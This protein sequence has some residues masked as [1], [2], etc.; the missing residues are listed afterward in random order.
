MPGYI[1]RPAPIAAQP[2]GLIGDAWVY[3]FGLRANLD[4]I[5]ATCNAYLN[6]AA[7]GGLVYEPA[8]PMAVVTFLNAARMTSAA[9]PYG[10]MAENECAVWVPLLAT[11]T[12]GGH[13]VA[14]R[15]VWWMPYVFVDTD[16]A[17]ATGRE[18]WGYPKQIGWFSVPSGPNPTWELKT[19]LFVTLNPDTEGVIAPLITIAS[20][21]GVAHETH[22]T[23]TH[24]TDAARDVLA[25]VRR[26]ISLSIWPSL[27]LAGNV[28]E[29]LLHHEMPVVN[30]KQFRDCADPTRACYQAVVEAP[31]TVKTFHGGG[32]LSG[33][34]RVTIASAESHPIVKELGL[35]GFE[36]D[37]IYGAWC[38]MDF[39][40]MPGTEVWR[41][42]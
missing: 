29:T 9:A 37:A 33:P 34:H 30:L 28:L 24:V 31:C 22:S 39:L 21:A 8:M 17:M 25:I 42:T 10:W 12:S 1:E 6:P 36:V 18:V 20:G 19:R 3:A 15:L 13:R 32:L 38:H 7:G 40:A 4:A 27:S 5:A 14:K 16:A 41:S 35:E 11:D 26:E 23:W 2:P